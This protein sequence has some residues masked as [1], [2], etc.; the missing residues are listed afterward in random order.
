MFEDMVEKLC[1]HA[2]RVRTPLWH[3]SIKEFFMRT[4]KINRP[5][6][7][8]V[9]AGSAMKA[10][11]SDA[12]IIEG[13]LNVKNVVDLGDDRTVDGCFR[14][15]ISEAYSRKATQQL[16]GLW[17]Y[18][19]NH[20]YDSIPLGI[21]VDAEE[22][23][24]GL[25]IRTQ[26]NMDL[27]QSRDL[28]SSVKQGG[29]TS[30]S[31]GYKTH[32][33]GYVREGSKSI[34]ELKEVQILEASCVLFAM[35]PES[36]ITAVKSGGRSMLT[37]MRQEKDFNDRYRMQQL[38]DWLY[39]DWYDLTT[40][41][42][43]SIQDLF[44]SGDSPMQDLENIVLND[45]DNS[46]GFLTALRNYIAEGIALDYSNYLQEQQSGAND[47]YPMMMSAGGASSLKAGRAISAANHQTISDA[48][49]N[50]MKHTR[51]IV[52]VLDEAQRSSQLQ[53]YPRTMSS[54]SVFEQKEVDED[55][56][57]VIGMM[58]TSL[59]VENTLREAKE[60]L[61]P[62]MSPA[63]SGVDAALTKLINSHKRR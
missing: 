11:S 38:D 45:S 10:V 30:Q 7:H 24:K 19:F 61:T 58:A 60:A 54:P 48:T 17:P 16:A 15:S 44:A 40:A 18:L 41:L 31:M 63:A 4:A 62:E 47:A 50:I 8:K 25:F 12:G 26:L 6:E 22:D 43:Q 23:R 39:A 36:T 27:Q 55:T 59:E 1:E 35:N 56:K 9:I 2:R 20:S 46:Q 29:L 3:G 13:Y 34:R 57:A 33:Y 14:K 28:F 42:K 32:Q 51:R 49:T 21:V 53:G 5:V 52:K 37:R